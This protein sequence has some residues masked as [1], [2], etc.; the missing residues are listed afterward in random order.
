MVVF[1]KIWLFMVIYIWLFIKK[2]PVGIPQK[3]YS[4]VDCVIGEEAYSTIVHNY[5][6]PI[7]S[8]F[9]GNIWW[10]LSS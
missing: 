8:S 6:K 7:P 10:G 1:V 3:T 5:L 4:T 9:S 2:P